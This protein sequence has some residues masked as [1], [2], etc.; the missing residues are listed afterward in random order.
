MFMLLVAADADVDTTFAT[1]VDLHGAMVT[2]ANLGRKQIRQHDKLRLLQTFTLLAEIC[3]DPD[4]SESMRAR[5]KEKEG[6][7][8]RME[9]GV[10][11]Y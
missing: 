8:R 5:G 11:T 2:C 9:M 7:V 10:E 4:G 1:V 6:R 3:T